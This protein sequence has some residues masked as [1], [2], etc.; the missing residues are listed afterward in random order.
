MDPPKQNWTKEIPALL[1]KILVED[2]SGKKKRLGNI[3][4]ANSTA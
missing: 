4:K 2:V 3:R 1:G